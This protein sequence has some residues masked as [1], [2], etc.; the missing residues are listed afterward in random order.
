M[1][2]ALALTSGAGASAADD[3]AAHLAKAPAAVQA[4]AHKA[5]GDKKLAEFAKEELD[6]KLV[7]E[8]GWKE[9]DVDHAAIIDATGKLLQTEA[10]VELDK[11]PA[12]VTQAAKKAHPEGKI[13][14]AALATADGKE[15]Y[16]LDVEVGKE[17]HVMSVS[18][19]G[20]VL[21]DAVEKEIEDDA[22]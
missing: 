18:A 22:K 11:V 6:G 21:A 1:A 14:E 17:K 3:A 8:V 16:S 9:G 15:F 10:D 20:K 19:D 5:L 12:A 2:L 13:K 7:Y 4:T